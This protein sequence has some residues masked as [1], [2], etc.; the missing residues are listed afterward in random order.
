MTNIFFSQQNKHTFVAT[1]EVFVATKMILVAV[2]ANDTSEAAVSCLLTVAA[3]RRPW[4]T[5]ER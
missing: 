5:K 2:P 3:L 1:E 4:R